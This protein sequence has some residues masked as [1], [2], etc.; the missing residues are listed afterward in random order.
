MMPDKKYRIYIFLVLVTMFLSSCLTTGSTRSDMPV[1]AYAGAERPV[2]QL[3]VIECGIGAKVKAVDGNKEYTCEPLYGKLHIL[4]GQRSFDVWMELYDGS[5][6][7][8]SKKGRAIR[9]KATAGHTYMITALQD[10]E[11][12]Y[13]QDG[14]F[15]VV[16]DTDTSAKGE[17]WKVHPNKAFI[18]KK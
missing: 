11:D 10:K 6:T 1:K 12:D 17:G 5:G 7:W 9:F 4:P 16:H 15:V 13:K 8:R 14:W 18:G 3:A 2:S